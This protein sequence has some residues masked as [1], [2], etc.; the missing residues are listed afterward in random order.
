MSGVTGAQAIST[1]SA[2]EVMSTWA[3]AIS[4]LQLL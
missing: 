4:S 2:I 3:V 1:S